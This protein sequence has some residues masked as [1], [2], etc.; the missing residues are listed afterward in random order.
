MGVGLSWSLAGGVPG[1]RKRRD[2]STVHSACLRSSRQGGKL[3]VSSCA[4]NIWLADGVA[5]SREAGTESAAK[6]AGWLGGCEAVCPL[7]TFLIAESG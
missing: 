1:G 4:E 3:G 6:E 7:G 2:P 5:S